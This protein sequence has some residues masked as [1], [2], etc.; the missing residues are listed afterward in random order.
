MTPLTMC[1]WRFLYLKSINFALQANEKIRSRMEVLSVDI[2]GVQKN[3]ADMEAK[4]T[5]IG[6]ILETI[7]TLSDQTNLL[8]LNAAT[9]A[10]RAGGHG[11]GFAVVADEVRK[12]A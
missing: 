10:A 12:L 3:A 6:S 1:L 9:E 4:V 7:N 11:R 8:A 2:K 5:E